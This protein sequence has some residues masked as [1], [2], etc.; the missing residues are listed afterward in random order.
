MI[1]ACFTPMNE[2]HLLFCICHKMSFVV[3]A[4]ENVLC[5]RGLQTA[6]EDKS[7]LLGTKSR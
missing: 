1:D 3:V 4:L 7:M 6:R 5:S 2:N